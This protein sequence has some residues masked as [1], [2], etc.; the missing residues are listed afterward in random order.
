MRRAAQ[1]LDSLG[2]Y[3]VASNREKADGLAGF[4][5][6]VGNFLLAGLGS[7]YERREV[8]QRN[9]VYNPTLVVGHAFPG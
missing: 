6:L 3:A 1:R 2:S 4:C 5:H 9:P 7:F 8:E